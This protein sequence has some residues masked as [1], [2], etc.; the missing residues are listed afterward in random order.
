MKILDC[1][2][3][4]MTQNYFLLPAHMLCCA[5]KVLDTSTWRSDTCPWGFSQ[6]IYIHL[7]FLRLPSGC[8]C[9]CLN[10]SFFLSTGRDKEELVASQCLI[11]IP[12]VSH[13]IWGHHHLVSH[14]SP[15]RLI[16]HSTDFADV[17]SL[18]IAD[19]NF[20]GIR[21]VSPK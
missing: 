4:N 14:T 2:E 10:S 15:T 18:S 20:S 12:V 8:M 17:L 19:L 7:V 1:R 11:Q 21:Y 9:M 16:S 5:F 6:V 13:N 3:S